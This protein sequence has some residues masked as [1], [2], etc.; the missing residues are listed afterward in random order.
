[1]FDENTESMKGTAIKTNLQRV[2]DTFRIP[3]N[4][5]SRNNKMTKGYSKIGISPR[6]YENVIRADEVPLAK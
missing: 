5:F 4:Y 2:S 3:F 1:M 6:S